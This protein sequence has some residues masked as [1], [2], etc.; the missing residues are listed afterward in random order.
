MDRLRAMRVYIKSLMKAP[1]P[2]GRRQTRPRTR[3]SSP[4]WWPAAGEHLGVRLLNRTTRSL[5]LTEA[6]RALPRSACSASSST[7]KTPR[8]RPTSRPPGRAAWCRVLASPDVHRAQLTEHL[9]RL[10]AQYPSSPS[11]LTVAEQRGGGG[12]QHDISISPSSSHA[13]GQLRR[14]TAGALEMITCAAGLSRSL[15][16]TQ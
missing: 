15:R 10:R 5:A 14:A 16:Y 6:K 11:G 9:P 1:S 8:R 3:Q 12:R 7:S 13:D 4:G 2:Q